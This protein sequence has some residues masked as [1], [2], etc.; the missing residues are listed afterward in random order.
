MSSAGLHV[1]LDKLSRRTLENPQ[2]SAHQREHLFNE[3][4]IT[5]RAEAAE[6][7]HGG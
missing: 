4:S 1:P 5:G 2:L 6:K 7:E 3:D